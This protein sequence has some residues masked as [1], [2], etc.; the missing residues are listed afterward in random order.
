M[1]N[2]PPVN[3]RPP[4]A[5]GI[6]RPPTMDVDYP[7]HTQAPMPQTFTP[8]SSNYPYT[9]VLP[10]YS[11]QT[12]FGQFPTSNAP[13]AMP[14][15]QGVVGPS[16]NRYGMPGYQSSAP[17]QYPP[18]PTDPHS[19]E[20]RPGPSEPRM[21]QYI[22]PNPP[23]YDWNPSLVPDQP[24]SRRS[25]ITDEELG[26]TTGSNTNGTGTAA[27]SEG[28]VSRPTTAERVKSDQT[29]TLKVEADDAE[30]DES[31]M[32][33]RKRKRNRTIRSCVPCHNHKRKVSRL[34]NIQLTYQCDRKRPCGRC[35]ALGLTGTCVY[36]VDD[37]RDM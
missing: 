20:D 16:Y 32:D 15:I 37:A 24:Y 3:G 2:G 28:D 21:G 19:T 33:H 6:Y 10:H 25:T 17:T 5:S 22:Y 35:T 14:A 8:P 4:P 36:E 12:A 9:N 34:K 7:Q 23:S 30:E 26:F 11:P 29:F 31:K 27:H 1:E 13:L 18:P